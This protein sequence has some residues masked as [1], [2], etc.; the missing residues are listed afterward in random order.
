MLFMNVAVALVAGLMLF[1]PFTRA[2]VSRF[3]TPRMR[4]SLAHRAFCQAGAAFFAAL[5]IATSPPAPERI[6]PLV[7]YS[8]ALLLV[9]AAVYWI[10]RGKRLL[11]QPRVFANMY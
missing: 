9:C 1:E 6:S 7:V 10:G 8:V 11:R 2:P 3:T 5:L 4:R